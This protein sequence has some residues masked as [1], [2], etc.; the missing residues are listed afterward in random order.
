MQESTIWGGMVDEEQIYGGRKDERQVETK[1]VTH[2]T[3]KRREQSPSMISSK[4]LALLV[5]VLKQPIR[6]SCRV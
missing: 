5:T 6:V 3:L 4:Q 1:Q 2:H